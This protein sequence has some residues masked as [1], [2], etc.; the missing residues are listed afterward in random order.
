MHKGY[1]SRRVCLCVCVC[2]CLKS[3]L[4]LGASVRFENA[5]TNS[6]GDDGQKIVA[7]SLT[8]LLC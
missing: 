1:G 7:F 3:H 2:V 4:T 8:L 5:V 6:V